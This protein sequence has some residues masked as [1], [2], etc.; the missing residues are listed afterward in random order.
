MRSFKTHPEEENFA[1]IVNALILLGYKSVAGFKDV[2]KDK[3]VKIDDND[4][5][6]IKSSKSLARMLNMAVLFRQCHGIKLG[7]LLESFIDKKPSEV[8]S[9]LEKANVFYQKE[10]EE[11]IKRSMKSLENDKKREE[12]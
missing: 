2:A 1:D 4:I 3:G 9:L 10:S 7:D 5:R 11:S 8:K 12:E 6:Y